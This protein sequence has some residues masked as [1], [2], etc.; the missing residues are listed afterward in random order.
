ML[1][2]PY[3]NRNPFCL[4]VR[5][6]N[7]RKCIGCGGEITKQ[8]AAPENLI[9]KHMERYQYP[10]E[11]PLQPFMYTVHKEKPHYYHARTSCI[12]GRHPYLTPNVMDLSKIASQLSE[13]QKFRH[14]IMGLDIF[15]P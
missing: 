9:L 13:E 5:H 15:V 2:Q 7:I 3:H 11:S 1:S 4:E 8:T 6:G 12:I 10:T 14:V